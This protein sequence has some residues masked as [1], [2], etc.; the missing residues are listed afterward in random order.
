MKKDQK[1]KMKK[2]QSII[3]TLVVYFMYLYNFLNQMNECIHK[4]KH[5]FLLNI[6]YCRQ[7][8]K[9]HKTLSNNKINIFG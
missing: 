4:I 6:S 9:N 8:I 2:V 7:K 3:V 5:F 1:F